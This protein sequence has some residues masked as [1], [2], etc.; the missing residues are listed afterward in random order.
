MPGVQKGKKHAPGA[1]RPRVSPEGSRRI[2]ITL[3]PAQYDYITAQGLSFSAVIRGLIN[4]R[5]H[6]PRQGAKSVAS[7]AR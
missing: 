5:L 1:G 6:A 3:T 7:K 2:T 4:D